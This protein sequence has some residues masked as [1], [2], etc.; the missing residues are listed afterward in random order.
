MDVQLGLKLGVELGVKR[1]TGQRSTFLTRR[2]E[3]Q[4]FRSVKDPQT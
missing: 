3:G 4:Q 2:S 1:R